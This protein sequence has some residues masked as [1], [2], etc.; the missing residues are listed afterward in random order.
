MGGAIG[1]MIGDTFEEY[2]MYQRKEPKWVSRFSARF[3]TRFPRRFLLR[4]TP[5]FYSDL[6]QISTQIYARFDPTF[7]PIFGT[8]VDAGYELVAT[9]TA[10]SSS[11]FHR[12]APLLLLPSLPGGILRPARASG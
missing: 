5:D 2:F 7:G 9:E 10:R 4:F 11:Q 12:L 1:Q 8:L 6:R 3:G